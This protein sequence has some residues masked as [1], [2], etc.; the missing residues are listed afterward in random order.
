[1]TEQR[2]I[3]GLS[4]AVIALVSLITVISFVLSYEVLWSYALAGGKSDKLAWLWPVIIDL[5]IVV[6]SVV[7]LFAVS[8]G[9]NPWPFRIV[10]GLVTGGT[11]YFNYSYAIS[12]G[13]SWQV[14]ITAP[15]MYFVSFEVLA[16]VIKV[17][18]E[19]SVLITKMAEISAKLGIL[20]IEYRGKKD[21]LKSELE[22]MEQARLAEAEEKATLKQAEIESLSI[23]QATLQS[24]VDKASQKLSDIQRQIEAKRQELNTTQDATLV[25]VWDLIGHIEP[26]TLDNQKR[27]FF[28]ALLVNAKVSQKDIAEWAGKSIKTI[29]RDIAECNGLVR[30]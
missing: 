25:N 23:Q 14:Y 3:K 4:I 20:E 15:I 21:N 12:Q 9:Y 8:L 24:E 26:A 28:V 17:V 7:A 1:M 19:R 27:Q 29:Q 30:K 10:V 13:V 16:W 6:F 18:S 11:V 5:P 2:Y 22:K